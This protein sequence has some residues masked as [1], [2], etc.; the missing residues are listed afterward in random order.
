MVPHAF[1]LET[2]ER[3][4]VVERRAGLAHN[5]TK[6]EVR[7]HSETMTLVSEDLYVC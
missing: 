7:E 1:P 4:P 2:G 5:N 6:G 3:A